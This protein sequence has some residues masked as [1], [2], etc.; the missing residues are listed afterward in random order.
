MGEWA[1]YIV[2]FILMLLSIAVGVGAILLMVRW[3]LKMHPEL[4][5][6]Y[7]IFNKTF[8][9]LWLIV[10]LVYS[11]VMWIQWLKEVR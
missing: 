4:S 2:V 9:P 1:G 10:S 11:I 7:R 6:K 5:H 3:R 8:V